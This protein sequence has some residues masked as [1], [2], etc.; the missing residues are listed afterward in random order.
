MK[1]CTVRPVKIERMYWL[2]ARAI[3]RRMGMGMGMSDCL[4]SCVF[5]AIDEVT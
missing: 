1:G 3:G 4:P 2:M 5:C